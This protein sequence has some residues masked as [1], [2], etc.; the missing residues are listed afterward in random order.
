M[1]AKTAQMDEWPRQAAPRASDALGGQ[2]CGLQLSA[3][4]AKG[5]LRLCHPTSKAQGPVAPRPEGCSP[6]G[7]LLQDEPRPLPP[8]TSASVRQVLPHQARDGP[9]APAEP[10]VAAAGPVSENRGDSVRLWHSGC[11]NLFCSRK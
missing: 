4:Y 6:G 9:P 10:R 11:R 3:V 8:P 1:P 2:G 5:T 7:L